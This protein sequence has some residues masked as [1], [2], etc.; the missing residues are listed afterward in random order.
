M[1]R[2]INASLCFRCNPGVAARVW[3]ND[4]DFLLIEAAYALPKWL[5]PETASNRVWLLKGLTHIVPLPTTAAP[6]LPSFPSLQQARRIVQGDQV[7]TAAGAPCCCTAQRCCCYL[8]WPS[9]AGNRDC[10]TCATVLGGTTARASK[11]LGIAISHTGER[12]K[13]GYAQPGAFTMF[14][15]LRHGRPCPLAR[16]TGRSPGN[17]AYMTSTL[18]DL[19]LIGG[20]CC[21]A[22][23]K[24]QQAI[25][26]RLKGYPQ[27]AHRQMHRARVIL[28]AK[29]AA[30]LHADP[31]L[32]GPA[33]DA[34]YNRDVDDM[35]AAARMRH[36]AP[37]VL[38]SLRLQA[39][40][41]HPWERR[42]P[43]LL[44]WRSGMLRSLVPRAHQFLQSSRSLCW[45][46]DM[47]RQLRRWANASVAP[48]GGAICIQH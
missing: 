13:C 2:A 9:T 30:V 35:Q 26:A 24:V 15:G 28:P 17:C 33:V 45:C 3:D 23:A 10:I 19:L 21:C 6:D 38:P 12:P 42:C 32:A 18:G 25:G 47:W 37:Q 39:L 14:I 4:G 48:Y 22:G 43:C 7:S 40:P 27:K 29:V 16:V 20:S 1:D 11:S 46:A 41:L 44:S 5:K 36:F 31:G 8:T 34:F